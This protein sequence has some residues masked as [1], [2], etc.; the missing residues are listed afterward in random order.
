MRFLFVLS[1]CIIAF[2]ATGAFAQRDMP[3]YGDPTKLEKHQPD[4]SQLPPGYVP[5]KGGVT[6]LQIMQQ[7]KREKAQRV[8]MS[9]STKAI[10]SAYRTTVQRGNKYYINDPKN[11]YL[12]VIDG[13]VPV[14]R[15]GYTFSMILESVKR[16]TAFLRL[17]LIA[18]ST[19][20]EDLLKVPMKLAVNTKINLGKNPIT[21]AVIAVEGLG[22]PSEIKCSGN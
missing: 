22:I 21:S 3:R 14:P 6:D 13:L 1:F 20:T 9:C 18:P 10:Y 19:E 2:T 11:E 15:D 12:F 17:K 5:P 4:P 16:D 8:E 7:Q